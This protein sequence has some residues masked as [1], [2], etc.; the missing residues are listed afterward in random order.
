MPLGSEQS[1]VQEEALISWRATDPSQRFVDHLA[2]PVSD[3]DSAQRFYELQLGAELLAVHPT[4]VELQL[5]R[6][7]SLALVP[8]GRHPLHL[9][10]YLPSPNRRFLTEAERFESDGWLGSPLLYDPDG[11][12]L[13]F[14]H[15][16]NRRADPPS[17]VPSTF[18]CPYCGQ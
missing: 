6:N 7:L 15:D 3:L 11:N 10:L 2:L 5:T 14:V 1:P 17:K 12:A 4:R 8:R 9:G 18:R 13:E 16:P